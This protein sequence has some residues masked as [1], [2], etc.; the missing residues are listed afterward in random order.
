MRATFRLIRECGTES[1]P[2]A[3]WSALEGPSGKVV[4]WLTGSRGVAEQSVYS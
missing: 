4:Y 3:C 2:F 1:L